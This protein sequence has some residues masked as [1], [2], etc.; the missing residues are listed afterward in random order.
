MLV[1]MI[2]SWVLLGWVG[3][4]IFWTEEHDLKAED[5]PII[6]I[7]GFVGLFMFI[8][9]VLV[10]LFRKNGGVLIKRR[11]RKLNELD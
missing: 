2:I 9:A 10:L 11:E 6:I 3:A 1:V 5:L 4:V 8:P 7:G